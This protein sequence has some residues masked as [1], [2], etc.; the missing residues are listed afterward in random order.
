MSFLLFSFR[1]FAMKKI[2]VGSFFVQVP[3]EMLAVFSVKLS[4]KK[5]RYTHSVYYLYSFGSHDEFI[6][7]HDIYICDRLVCVHA[8]LMAEIE[9]K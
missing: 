7:N 5:I 9:Y 6:V 1:V 8:D 4:K 2:H 3:F